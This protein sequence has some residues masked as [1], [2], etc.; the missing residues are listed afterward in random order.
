MARQAEV[1]LFC[2]DQVFIVRFMG[3]MARCAV[4]CRRGSVHELV[5]YFIGMA[6]STKVFEGLYKEL[7]FC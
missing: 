5:V 6:G 2:N 3:I 4:A 1:G 7:R